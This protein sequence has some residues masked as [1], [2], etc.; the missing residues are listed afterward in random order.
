MQIFSLCFQQMKLKKTEGFLKI[1]KGK[2][3]KTMNIMNQNLKTGT[4][5][6]YLLHKLAEFSI[7]VF[8]LPLQNFYFSSSFVISKACLISFISQ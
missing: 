3:V 6:K 5:P 7:T 1:K 4:D 8:S 2:Y